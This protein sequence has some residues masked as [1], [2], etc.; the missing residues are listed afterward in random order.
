MADF[1]NITNERAKATLADPNSARLAVGKSLLVDGIIYTS[2]GVNWDSIGIKEITLANLGSAQSVSVGDKRSVILPDNSSVVVTAEG[3]HWKSQFTPRK[4]KLAAWMPNILGYVDSAT[5]FTYHLTASC[6]V[7]DFDAVALILQNQ[8]VSP[9]TVSACVAVSESISNTK[10]IPVIGGSQYNS[11]AA[12]GTQNGFI[13]VTLSS[14]SSIVIPASTDLMITDFIPLESLPRTDGGA[15]PIVM[16]RIYSSAQKTSAYTFSSLTEKENFRQNYNGSGELYQYLSYSGDYVTNPAGWTQPASESVTMRIKGFVFRA[17][18][19]VDANVLMIG[20]SID[21]GLGG[22]GDVVTNNAGNTTGWGQLA[23]N[24]LNVAGKKIGCISAGW[25]GKSS[26]NFFARGL[27]LIPIFKPTVC[28]FPLYTP[29]DTTSTWAGVQAAIDRANSFIEYCQQNGVIP[30]V[31]TPI[32]Y[33]GSGSEVLRF[34][35][36]QRAL[37][38]GVLC[39]DVNGDLHDANNSVGGYW[40]SASYTVDGTHPSASGQLLMRA[41]A[42]EILNLIC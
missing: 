28:I 40:K 23:V 33:S 13:P 38:S 3:G 8:D 35:A 7:G 42:K 17:R 36:V 26:P 31:R 15:Q 22:G 1:I 24:D 29:N 37:K 32:P 9:V 16:A 10:S 5:T 25:S 34:K 4:T 21:H 39:I 27:T 18:G 14:A 20:D 41:K 30:V 2:D 12:A 11:I 6:P 19:S